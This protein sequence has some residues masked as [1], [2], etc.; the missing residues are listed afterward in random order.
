MDFYRKYWIQGAP[1]VEF[2]PFLAWGAQKRPFFAYRGS[3]MS[4]FGKGAPKSPPG[5]VKQIAS[6][7]V[8]FFRLGAPNVPLLKYI[9]PW[10]TA[11]ELG[12]VY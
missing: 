6:G 12:L 1:K 2:L 4:L 3:K 7:F 8:F 10:Q 9:Y 11:K 5:G